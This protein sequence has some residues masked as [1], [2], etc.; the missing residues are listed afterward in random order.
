MKRRTGRRIL[1]VLLALVMMLSLLPASVFASDT[2]TARKISSADQLTS[3]QYVLVNEA[4][5]APT[6][7]DGGWVTPTAVTASGNTVEVAPSLLWTITVTDG[8]V[9]LTDSKGRS[10][11][12][13]RRRQRH[14]VRELHLDGPHVPAAPLPSPARTLIQ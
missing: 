2:V 12:P 14:Q 13:R 4:G 8:G 5:Y 3:G 6:V 10:S 9:T 7:L 1:S 11:P